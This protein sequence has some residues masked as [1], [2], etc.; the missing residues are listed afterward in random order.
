MN[1][2][3]LID[4][5]YRELD[6]NGALRFDYQTQIVESYSGQDGHNH[7]YEFDNTVH[8]QAA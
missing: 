2:V 8:I 6:E 4:I 7:R 5:L 3:D 1:Y